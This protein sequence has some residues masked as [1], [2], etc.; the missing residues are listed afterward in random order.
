[1]GAILRVGE[2]PAASREERGRKPSLTRVIASD[3]YIA[4]SLSGRLIEKGLLAA[5]YI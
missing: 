3:M 2:R 4:D 5:V 1:M